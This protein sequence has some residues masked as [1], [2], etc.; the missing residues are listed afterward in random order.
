[1]TVAALVAGPAMR[2]MRAAPGLMPLLYRRQV[3]GRVSPCRAAMLKKQ[4]W[5][6]KASKVSGAKTSNIETEYLFSEQ[7]RRKETI[8]INWRK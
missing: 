3:A 2:K 8:T 4:K 5:Q 1:M 7:G 6:M